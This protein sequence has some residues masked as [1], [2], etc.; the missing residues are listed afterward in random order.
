MHGHTP[1]DS[2]GA[3]VAHTFET[4][5]SFERGQLD[6]RMNRHV[7]QFKYGKLSLRRMESNTSRTGTLSKALSIRSFAIRNLLN[8]QSYATEKKQCVRRC[9]AHVDA[10]ANAYF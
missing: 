10:K 4:R 2:P 9:S 1:F 6:P 7:R 3:A 8:L 5:S